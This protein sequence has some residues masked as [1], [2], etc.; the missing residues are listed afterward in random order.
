MTVNDHP[1]LQGELRLAGRL[2]G[3]FFDL[4]AALALTGSLQK[5]AKAAGYSYKGAWLV[6]DAAQAL[7]HAP[8]VAKATGG[9]GGGGTRLTVEGDALLAAWR[10]LQSRHAAFLHEQAAWLATQPALDALLKR[11]SMKT[12]ARNQFFGRIAGV[13]P[14][15]ATTTVRVALDG[16]QEVTASLTTPAAHELNVKTGKEALALVKSSEVVLVTD[17]GGYKLSAR[18]QLAGTVSRVERGAVSSLIG[19]TLPGGMVVTASVTND[20]VDGLGLTVGQPATAVFKAYAV[21]LAVRD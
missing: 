12:T 7:T 14:G 11:M 15:P 8:L 20:S 4:L 6:L 18:N 16:G 5:A 1:L 19:L 17:F 10:E 21:M 13:N 3:R 9:A 2:D